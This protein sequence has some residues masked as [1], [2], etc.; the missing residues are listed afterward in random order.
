VLKR[1]LDLAG[2]LD[3]SFIQA[4]LFDLISG[5]QAHFEVAPKVTILGALD[6]AKSVGLGAGVRCIN[7]DA[8]V[9]YVA[10]GAAAM[11]APTG[12]TDGIAI[13]AGQLVVINTADLGDY[14]RSDSNKVG[15]YLI[16]RDSVL[17]SVP[18]PNS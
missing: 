9:H 17:F 7:T 2:S 3:I 18:D 13:P 16:Y 11:A 10:I 4:V 6:A 5:G 14:I 12:F 15:G 1:K 8:V